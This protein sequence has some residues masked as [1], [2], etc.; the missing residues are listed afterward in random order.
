M[1]ARSPTYARSSPL[2]SPERRERACAERGALMGRAVIT[3]TRVRAR[4]TPAR[5]EPLQGGRGRAP[6][7][8]Q[9]DSGHADPLISSGHPGAFHS[10]VHAKHSQQPRG[11]RYRRYTER[12]VACR[13]LELRRMTSSLK[14]V[15]HKSRGV[16]FF[17]II[18]AGTDY[19]SGSNGGKGDN[20]GWQKQKDEGIHFYFFARRP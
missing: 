20:R 1:L 2:S 14:T 4:S 19:I 16:F 9:V 3:S 7:N 13:S 15:C 10:S 17:V 5:Y 11:R 18:A 12:N 6:R 8:A